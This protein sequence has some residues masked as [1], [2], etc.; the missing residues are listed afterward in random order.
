MVT[1]IIGDSESVLPKNCKTNTTNKK[2]TYIKRRYK[3]SLSYC[4]LVFLNAHRHTSIYNNKL[5]IYNFKWYIWL[6]ESF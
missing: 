3:K 2:Y 1:N 5:S 6:T 4:R